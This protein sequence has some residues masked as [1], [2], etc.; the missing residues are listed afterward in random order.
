MMN[1]TE[2]FYKQ[3]LQRLD[4]LEAWQ[5]KAEHVLDLEDPGWYGHTIEQLE[6]RNDHTPYGR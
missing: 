5:E 1:Q 4:K 6:R 3:I 2:S